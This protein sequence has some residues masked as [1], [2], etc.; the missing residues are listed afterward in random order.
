MY[1]TKNW[2]YMHMNTEHADTWWID[3][4]IRCE[5]KNHK[6]TLGEKDN[7]AS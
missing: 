5:T 1:A 4:V 6:S 7:A 2:E 3:D